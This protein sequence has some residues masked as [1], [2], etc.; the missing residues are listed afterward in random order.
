M[1]RVA[2]IERITLDPQKTQAMIVAVGLLTFVSVGMAACFALIAA[3]L[4]LAVQ[5]VLIVLQSVVEAFAL[6]HTT[7][8]TADPFLRLVILAALGYGV[9]RFYQSRLKRN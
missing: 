5:F 7:W 4:Y 2:M 9:Y 3:A 8:V 1:R 6:M